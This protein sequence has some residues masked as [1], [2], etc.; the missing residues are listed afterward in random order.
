MP[1][2]KL[3]QKLRNIW[4]ISVMDL[5]PRTFKKSPNLVALAVTVKDNEGDAE[6]EKTVLTIKMVFFYY[7][8]LLI[9]CLS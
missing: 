6:D 9:F 5:S 2:F 8:L 4:A 1:F 3:V 7:S